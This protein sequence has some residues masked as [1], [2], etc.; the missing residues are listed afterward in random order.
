MFCSCNYSWCCNWQDI[1]EMWH[2][3]CCHC[4]HFSLAEKWINTQ[5][6]FSSTSQGSS[7]A[8]QDGAFPWPWW[9]TSWCWVA[10]CWCLGWPTSVVTGRYFKLLSSAPCCWCCPTS[11]KEKTRAPAAPW[12][13]HVS[14]KKV[15]LNPT[16]ESASGLICGYACS[17][18]LHLKYSLFL[19]SG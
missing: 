19:H 3:L 4:V 11:G 16:Q 1:L 8:C 10:S 2:L 17:K 13:R 12:P 5:H 18:N 9:L 6:P 15:F 7:C 14:F